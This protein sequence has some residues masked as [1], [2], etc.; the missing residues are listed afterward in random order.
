MHL[1]G[2]D[3]GS[4]SIKAS[5][6]EASTGRCIASATH[7]ATEMEIQA[8]RPGWAEQ[9]PSTWWTNLAS[10]T[11]E[12]LQRS[13]IKPAGV[14]AIGISYQMHG[15]VVIGKEKQ[16]LRP[17]IL[18]CDSRAVEIGNQAFKEIGPDVCLDRL[19]NSPGNFTAS[20]L[21][22]IKDH[23]PEV[24]S[25][26]WKIML[27]GDYA[28]MRMTGE[29]CT[30]ASDLSEGIFWIPVQSGFRNCSGLLRLRP[31]LNSRAGADLR[32]AREAPGCSRRGS[33]AGCRHPRGISRGRST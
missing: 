15:L 25:R 2:Y 30:T 18:W 7:P 26:I 33:R 1:L 8:P 22:W 6:L 3:L 29:A 12:L 32:R 11:R 4:S 20:K 14:G 9:D 16:V 5:I 23:E 17:S 19:L 21:K 28:A 24:Y 27:P 31:I 10:A 13:A